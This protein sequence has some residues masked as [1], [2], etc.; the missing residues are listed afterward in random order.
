M[1]EHALRYH[2]IWEEVRKVLNIPHIFSHNMFLDR[3]R[4]LVRNSRKVEANI[5]WVIVTWPSLFH[6][7]A[8]MCTRILRKNRLFQLEVIVQT[9]VHF[10]T[11]ITFPATISVFA[12]NDIIDDVIKFLQVLLILGMCRH[13]LIIDWASVSVSARFPQLLLG[14][15]CGTVV[16]RLAQ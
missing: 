9:S 13:A 5:W 3:S 12:L 7:A 2:K 15:N 1:K 10:V 6:S 14:W 11:N 16:L 8:K 4:L